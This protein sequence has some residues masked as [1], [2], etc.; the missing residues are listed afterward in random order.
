M[1]LNS[2]NNSFTLFFPPEFFAD[3]VKEK[4]KK[5][6]QSL[7]LP[8]DTIED[9]MSSTI[10]K[11]EFPGWDMQPVSQTRSL[12]KVQD[13]KN[14]KPIPDLF[15]R[16]FSVTFKMTDG[17][18]NYWIFLD[19]AYNYLDFSNKS[20]DTFSPMRLSFLNNEGYMLTSVVFNKPI[21]K[22]QD[23]ISMSYS[24]VSPDFNTFKAKF[25]YFN[26]DIKVDFN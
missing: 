6:Y 10:Q 8:Y 13:Y 26:F 4:Y 2:R 7:I 15:T 5:Y 22:G 23:G 1:I 16:E 9:F 18:L 20:L 17:F 3:E 19:N 25:S 21:L 12:G 24:S 11:I 14:S